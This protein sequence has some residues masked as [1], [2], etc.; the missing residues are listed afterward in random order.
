MSAPSAPSYVRGMALL[1]MDHVS[2]VVE[3]LAG[4]IAFFEEL[5][6]EL[7][8]GMPVEGDWVD[9]V[10]GLA[11]VQ[12]DIAMMVTPDGHNKLELTAFKNPPLIKTEP[13]VMPPNA[14]GLRTVMFEVEDIADTVERLRAFGAALV[15]EI[16]DYEDIY[17]LCY[18][19]GPSGIIVALAQKL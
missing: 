14:L 6:L 8:N 16:A 15:G 2:I 11:N 18:L 19:R 10:T 9:R 7:E 1:R 5:G 4:A 3:D 13:T 17:R 12:V